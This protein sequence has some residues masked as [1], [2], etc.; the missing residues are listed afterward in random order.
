MLFCTDMRTR[1]KAFFHKAPP[2][3]EFYQKKES[4]NSYQQDN[5]CA[6]ILYIKRKELFL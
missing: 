2:S 3:F 5:L 1:I 4:M 6:K